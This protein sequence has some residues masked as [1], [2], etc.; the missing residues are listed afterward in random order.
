MKDYNYNYPSVICKYCRY[1]HYGELP[2]EYTSSSGFH[3]CEG[4]D[5]ENAV[6]NYNNVHNT[7]YT[8]LDVM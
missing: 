4:F 7:K 2:C 1:T 3:S 8:V 5:C 6:K